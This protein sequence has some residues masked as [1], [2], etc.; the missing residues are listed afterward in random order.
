MTSLPFVAMPIALAL[1]VF[2]FRCGSSSSSSSSASAPSHGNAVNVL[3]VSSVPG[4]AAGLLKKS[5][6]RHIVE[7]TAARVSERT[8]HGSSLGEH[9]T[10]IGNPGIDA[11]FNFLARRQLQ[12][13]II[14]FD[15]NLT[16]AAAARAGLCS[17]Y[18]NC[19]HCNHDCY[20]HYSWWGHHGCN[21][22]GGVGGTDSGNCGCTKEKCTARLGLGITKA[23]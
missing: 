5:T 17:S 11:G 7:E 13:Q 19:A 3:H 12:P 2:L 15:T 8:F 9:A 16:A 23:R 4:P 21:A 6:Q 14:M 18:I 20:C 10:A 1:C 22:C